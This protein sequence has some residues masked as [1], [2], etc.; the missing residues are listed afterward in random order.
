MCCLCI[1]KNPTD[2]DKKRAEELKVQ[3]MISINVRKVHIIKDT[4]T[5]CELSFSI[6]CEQIRRISI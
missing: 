6:N 4:F 1:Y 2:E 3:G 5:S